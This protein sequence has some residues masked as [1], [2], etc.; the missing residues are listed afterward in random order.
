MKAHVKRAT[1]FLPFLRTRSASQGEKADLARV[2][3]DL[4]R[5]TK[6]VE[7]VR[8]R[9]ERDEPLMSFCRGTEAADALSEALAPKRPK[10]KPETDE[11]C[12]AF[13]HPAHMCSCPKHQKLTKVKP[14]SSVVSKLRSMGLGEPKWK[15]S[16]K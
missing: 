1:K 2:L 10:V 14:E 5:A 16:R 8:R 9:V 11:R 15:R 4:E 13:M 12:T 3:D 6:F 7:Y